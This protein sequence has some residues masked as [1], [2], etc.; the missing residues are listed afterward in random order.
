MRKAGN[1]FKKNTYRNLYNRCF[2]IL[3]DFRKIKIR[4]RQRDFI[5]VSHADLPQ[6]LAVC[7]AEINSA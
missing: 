5:S 1:C 4:I 2:Y 7:D 6:F 3:T